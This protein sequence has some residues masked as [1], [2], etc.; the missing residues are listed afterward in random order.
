MS[1]RLLMGPVCLSAPMRVNKMLSGYN[2]S[3]VPSYHL[4]QRDITQQVSDQLHLRASKLIFH[5]QFLKNFIFSPS[6]NLISSRPHTH[7]ISS[8]FYFSLATFPYNSMHS[9]VNS[10]RILSC[11]WFKFY[12]SIHPITASSSLR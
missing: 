7:K 4:C 12:P 6:S 5:K 3:S 10:L 1:T 11:L 8:F 2:L 9:K